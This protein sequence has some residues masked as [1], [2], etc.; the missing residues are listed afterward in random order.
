[1][2]FSTIPEGMHENNR[3]P[4]SKMRNWGSEKTW[5][6]Q[7][8]KP[9]NFNAWIWLS[10]EGTHLPISHFS[11]SAYKKKKNPLVSSWWFIT[12]DKPLLWMLPKSIIAKMLIKK[13]HSEFYP[14]TLKNCDNFI[15]PIWMIHYLFGYNY[16]TLFNCIYV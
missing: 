8:Y 14:F 6:S 13:Y 11:S 10:E 1:M 3:I 16:W 7:V 5:V 15:F 2:I 12:S 4:I 9:L